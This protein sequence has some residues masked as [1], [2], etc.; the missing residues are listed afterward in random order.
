MTAAEKL[1]SVED[2]LRYD[3]EREERHEFIDGEIVAMT[4]AE[5]THGQIVANLT[6]L[7]QAALRPKGCFV[8]SQD[9]RVKVDHAYL[10]P[11]VV[12]ACSIPKFSGDKPASLLNPKVI[13]EVLSETTEGRD[14]NKKR[15]RYQRIAS[16]QQ[17]ILVDCPEPSVAIWTRGNDERWSGPEEV[18]EGNVDIAATTV[19]LADIYEGV[20]ALAA[21]LGS[22]P[23]S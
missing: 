2:Y 23:S 22:R 21:A 1:V 10:Y 5:P 13:V 18:A 3:L 19:R 6:S 16:L 20:A 15:K 17:Y 11:D 12:V 7:L 8:F 9:Q 4:G 14:W